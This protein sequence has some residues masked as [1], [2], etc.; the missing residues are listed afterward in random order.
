MAESAAE[1]LVRTQGEDELELL[2]KQH[3]KKP[4]VIP[5]YRSKSRMFDED[6]YGETDDSLAISDSTTFDFVSKVG[7]SLGH[8]VRASWRGIRYGE[9]MEHHDD[10]SGDE[11]G[12]QLTPIGS[13]GGSLS[14]YVSKWKGKNRFQATTGWYIREANHDPLGAD[15]WMMSMFLVAFAARMFYSSFVEAIFLALIIMLVEWLTWMIVRAAMPIVSKELDLS[16]SGI[17]TLV[18]NI[19]SFAAG[20]TVGSFV[21]HTWPG[22]LSIWEAL[23]NKGCGSNGVYLVWAPCTDAQT[24]IIVA[25]LFLMIIL[26]AFKYFYVASTV[27]ILLLIPLAK[28]ASTEF[29]VFNNILMTSVTSAFFLAW[30]AAPIKRTYV[31]NGLFALSAYLTIYSFAALSGF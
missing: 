10:E 5:S 20:I 15:P 2:K 30:M 27:I 19:F 22:L 6:A 12:E 4:E 28:I 7:S 1:I 21:L 16:E 31:W 29:D 24:F 11:S 26:S 3:K 13:A 9:T 25:L 8:A 23:E 14:E 18:Y 17:V